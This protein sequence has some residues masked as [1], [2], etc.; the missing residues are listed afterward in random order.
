MNVLQPEE[1]SILLG[2][3]YGAFIIYAPV[4]ANQVY[5][6]MVGMTVVAYTA[7]TNDAAS[8]DPLTAVANGL[9]AA[10]Q[11]GLSA[12][13]AQ[14]ATIAAQNN[15][16]GRVLSTAIQFSLLPANG[17]TVFS[18]SSVLNTVVVADGTTLPSPS[19]TV[20]DGNGN[21]ANAIVAVG[22][23]PICDAL[24]TQLINSS[25][26]LSYSQA[27]SASLGQVEFRQDELHVRNNI[28]ARYRYDMGVML[29][30]YPPNGQ[31]GIRTTQFQV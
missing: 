15:G 23:L 20:D 21:P 1:E 4:V 31:T 5:S 3:P 10:T 9:L 6:F 28:L 13:T 24:E 27:G 19:Y 11:A 18:L 30:F 7:T 29:S 8:P 26:N 2:K 25:Q 16:L 22:L 14:Y 12:Y 17:S